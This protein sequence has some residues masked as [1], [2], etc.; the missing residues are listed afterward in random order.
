MCRAEL[1]CGVEP[2]MSHPF[3]WTARS[4][5]VAVAQCRASDGRNDLAGRSLGSILSRF[6]LQSLR[7]FAD[8]VGIEPSDPDS[9]SRCGASLHYTAMCCRVAQ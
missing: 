4:V 2:G 1:Y 3:L 7:G 8:W 5:A 9:Q 6:G